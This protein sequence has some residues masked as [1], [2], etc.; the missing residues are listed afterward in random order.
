MTSRRAVGGSLEALTV[1]CLKLTVTK[2]VFVTGSLFR[3]S[4]GRNAASAESVL[5]LILGLAMLCQRITAP[6]G[7]GAWLR[8][9]RW[10]QVPGVLDL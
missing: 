8:L 6:D 5:N 1:N 9:E 4:L 3:S 7:E 10:V 2:E